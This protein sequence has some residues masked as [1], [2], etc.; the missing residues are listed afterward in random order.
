MVESNLNPVKDSKL[1][2]ASSLQISLPPWIVNPTGEYEGGPV[3]YLFAGMQY[4]RTQVRKSKDVQYSKT[5]VHGGVTGGQTTELKASQTF[6]NP[7]MA[8]AGFEKLFKATMGG[9]V[10]LRDW[11]GR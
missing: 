9:V 10:L 5:A 2:S 3:E 1:R 7:E 11:M 6:G 8:S 4:R